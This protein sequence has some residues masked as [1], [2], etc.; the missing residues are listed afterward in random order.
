MIASMIAWFRGPQGWLR[1]WHHAAV[2][3]GV[4]GEDVER[5]PVHVV[6]DLT[7]FS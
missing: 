4:A 3:V 7:I 1:G 6:R 2:A 5:D